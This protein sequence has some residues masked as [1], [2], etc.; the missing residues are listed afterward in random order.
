M[1]QF[2]H[3][4]ATLARQ[5]ATTVQQ[6]QEHILSLHTKVTRLRRERNANKISGSDFHRLY[7]CI[8]TD[9]ETS[10]A[11]IAKYNCIAQWLVPKG[12]NTPASAASREVERVASTAS[13]HSTAVAC[14]GIQIAAGT[15]SE[16][17]SQTCSHSNGQAPLP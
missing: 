17:E 16:C 5:Y 12:S 14:E 15:P 7:E 6:H 4:K 9:V 2:N 13:T 8:C 10:E 3:N 1:E 11:Y